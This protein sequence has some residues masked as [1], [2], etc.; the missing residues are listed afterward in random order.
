[1]V[2][3]VVLLGSIAAACAFPSH[4]PAAGGWTRRL[5]STARVASMNSAAARAASANPPHL[6]A[7]A[8]TTLPASKDEVVEHDLKGSNI[9]TNLETLAGL[10][11]RAPI[12]AMA[13]T[14]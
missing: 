7:D 5:P 11:R 9:V 12:A 10:G 1:M 6:V 4:L 3:A 14:V 8:P 13:A 2:R